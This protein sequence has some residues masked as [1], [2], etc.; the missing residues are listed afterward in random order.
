MS[1]RAE[2]WKTLF[3]KDD[4]ATCEVCMVTTHKNP[5]PGQFSECGCMKP[6]AIIEQELEAKSIE[7]LKE[8]KLAIEEKEKDDKEKLHLMPKVAP[9]GVQLNVFKEWGKSIAKVYEDQKGDWEEETLGDTL[10]KSMQL[11][12][13][14]Y[15]ASPKKGE[16]LDEFRL[17]DEGD[18]IK[19]LVACFKKHGISA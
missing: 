4:F 16:L 8:E 13:P 11:F 3:K 6:H 17:G 18:M 2:V 1:E 9:E 19:R 15:E 7:S 10:V 14:I 12:A 5:L